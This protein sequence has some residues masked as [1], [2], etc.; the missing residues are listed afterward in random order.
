MLCHST[1]GL[2]QSLPR[3]L[4]PFS[5]KLRIFQRGLFVA[6]THSLSHWRSIRYFRLQRNFENASHLLGL[7]STRC[8]AKAC[9][10]EHV[11][12]PQ[13]SAASAT[14]AASPSA[15]FA[16]KRRACPLSFLKEAN[17][18]RSPFASGSAPQGRGEQ[19][20]RINVQTCKA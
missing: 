12:A 1:L 14:G 9:Q 10:N 13:A 19:K 7:S 16:C 6:C 4:L 18:A 8:L 3:L 17:Q 20:R 11:S 5:Q 15:G 2:C